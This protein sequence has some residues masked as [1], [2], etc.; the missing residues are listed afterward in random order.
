MLNKDLDVRE[1]FNMNHYLNKNNNTGEPKPNDFG[2]RESL[3]FAIP[4]FNPNPGQNSG[5]SDGNSGFNPNSGGFNPNSVGFNPNSGGF[6]PNSGG[7]NPSFS[8]E[9]YNIDSNIKI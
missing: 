1:S 4:S 5:P 8:T 7:F 2:I 6:N 9:S 3:N